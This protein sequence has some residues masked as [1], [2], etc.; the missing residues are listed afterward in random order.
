MDKAMIFFKKKKKKKK[1]KSFSD[2][3]VLKS[4]IALDNFFSYNF[5][6]MLTFSTSTV[7]EMNGQK[8]KSHRHNTQQAT[9]N[10]NNHQS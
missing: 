5:L 8:K 2:K 3:Q 4:S 7:I 10:E 9:T 1:K 6:P